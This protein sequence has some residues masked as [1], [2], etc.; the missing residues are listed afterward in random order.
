[1]AYAILSEAATSFQQTGIRTTWLSERGGRF[2]ARGFD[3]QFPRASQQPVRWRNER[4]AGIADTHRSHV[5]LASQD[6]RHPAGGSSE[7]ACASCTALLAAL[8][9]GEGGR[10]N[11]LSVGKRLAR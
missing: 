6:R 1:M 5:K 7:F 4:I 10:A 11:R 9:S 2:D 8:V 3:L